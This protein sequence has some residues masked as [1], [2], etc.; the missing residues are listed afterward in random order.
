MTDLIKRLRLLG[1]QLNNTVI[2]DA[3]DEIHRLG[4]SPSPQDELD[5]KRYRALCQSAVIVDGSTEGMHSVTFAEGHV[6]STL[7]DF[8]RMVADRLIAAGTPL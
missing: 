7:T 5:A 8:V 1:M 2:L 6:N 3:A 4:A